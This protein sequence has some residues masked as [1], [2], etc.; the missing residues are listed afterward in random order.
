M[1]F[2]LLNE[3]KKRNGFRQFLIKIAAFIAIF[4]FIQMVTIS[5]SAETRLP[6]RLNPFYMTEIGKVGLFVALLFVFSYREKLF[7][8]KE[9][10][11]SKLNFVWFFVIE[12]IVIANYYLYKRF[13]LANPSIV[14]N[15][16]LIFIVGIYLF[17]ALML[18]M[19][20]IAIF[21]WPFL[22]YFFKKFKGELLLFAGIFI[23]IFYLSQLIQSLWYL[24]CGTVAHSVYWLLQYSGEAA[25]R[26]QQ[27]G[28]K[29]LPVIGIG[30]FVV[31]V[32]KPCSGIESLFL[33]TALY[34]FILAFFWKIL[35]KKKAAILF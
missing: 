25:F 20:L 10:K 8:L 22:E 3:L 27:F 32:V 9:Y 1:N 6:G 11:F 4:L 28:T 5:L 2:A 29:E 14:D 7:E 30:E 24:F 12:V 19:L 26:I 31:G 23:I 34:L 15:Y 18:G 33:F 16:L 17:Y 35:N 13:L 21:G